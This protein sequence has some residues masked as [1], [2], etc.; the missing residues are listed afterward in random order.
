MDYGKV[1]S[2][3]S[4]LSAI[5]IKA[6]GLFGGL[7][8]IGIIS[9]ILRTKLVALWIGPAGVGL[10]GLYNAALD[11]LSSATQLNIRSSAVREIAMDGND[12]S[13]IDT[14]VGVVRRWSWLLGLLGAF[15]VLLGAPLLSELTFGDKNHV[16]AFMWLSIVMLLYSLTGGESAILQGTRRLKKL[17]TASIWGTVA[18]TVV[19]IPLYYFFHLQ[20]IVPSIIVFALA[21]LIAVL[22]VK[23]RASS[24]VELPAATVLKKGRGL[25]VLGAF[26]TVSAFATQL[27]SY[28]FMSYI[29]HAGGE[30]AVGY[31]QSGFTLVNRYL[32]LIFTALVM[33][34]FP[35]LSTVSKSSR[36]LEVFVNHESGIVLVAMIP[37]VILFIAFRELIVELF[38]SSQFTVIHNYITWGAVGSVLRGISWCMA[39][40]I[41]A[42][43]DGKLYLLTELLSCIFY[44]AFNFAGYSMYGI[45]GLGYAYF[46]WYL[47]YTVVVLAV[48]AKKYGITLSKQVST[49]AIVAILLSVGA[50]ILVGYSFWLVFFIGGIAGVFSMSHIRKL[51]RN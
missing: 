37:A 50:A 7:Q 5:V 21:N 25:I 12:V 10:F 11:M 15:V 28:I 22:L 29:N 4:G 35:R 23:Y 30:E 41:L 13:A 26:L 45:D 19:S 1:S 46:L 47:A 51:L 39:Y 16:A 43:G 33:E 49:L 36:R 3:N 17:A 20:S 8:V 14:M 40:V 44:L 31:Y 32:G 34:Y 42:R 38:F 27:V 9:S 2:G 18:G 6:M 24:V 48:C